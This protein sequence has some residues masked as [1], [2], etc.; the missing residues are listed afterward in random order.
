[1]VVGGQ[2]MEAV[3]LAFFAQKRDWQDLKIAES[4]Y[5]LCFIRTFKVA[6]FS[7]LDHTMFCILHFIL[8][9][10]RGGLVD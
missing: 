7:L 5:A 2:S 10:A 8:I 1:M 3:D 6:P 4:D 9:H